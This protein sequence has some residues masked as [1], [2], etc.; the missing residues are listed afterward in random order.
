MMI[1]WFVSGIAFVIAV[2]KPVSER[3][4][5]EMETQNHAVV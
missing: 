5:L 1:G 3:H 2:T 4:R